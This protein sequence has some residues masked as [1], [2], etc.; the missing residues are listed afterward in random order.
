MLPGYGDN[1][2]NCGITY[3][4]NMEEIW[5]DIIGYEGLYMV[6]NCGRIKS[7]VLRSMD[8]ER[9]LSP[10]VNGSGY[11]LVGLRKKNKAVTPFIH[12]LI[13]IHFIQNPEGKPNINHIN[14]IK[15]DNRIENLEWCT[16]SE[17]LK[18][19]HRIGLKSAKGEKNSQSKIS[20]EQAIEIYKSKKRGFQLKL[21][22]NISSQTI[23]DIKKGRIW[24]HVT[25][26]ISL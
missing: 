5:K 16:Q 21:E 6:S 12:R 7:L 17:N 13:A 3:K 20:A 26:E 22:Y 15:T 8:R 23:C 25:N 18:H 11:K 14:G 4:F 19:A 1:I 2:C 10:T 9:I 24:A